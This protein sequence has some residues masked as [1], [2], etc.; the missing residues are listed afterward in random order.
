MRAC[1]VWVS[2]PT[3]R[4]QFGPVYTWHLPLELDVHVSRYQ[5]RFK[6]DG[7]VIEPCSYPTRSAQQLPTPRQ[8][9]LP[10]IMRPPVKKY[11]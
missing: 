5:R 1:S 10:A 4:Q 2:S 7:F 9:R 8:S 3:R 6:P 11:S